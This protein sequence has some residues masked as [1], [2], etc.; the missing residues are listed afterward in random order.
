[1]GVGQANDVLRYLP[2][3]RGVVSRVM[4]VPA[5][6]KVWERG[7]VFQE[8]YLL[9]LSMGGEDLQELPSGHLHRVLHGRIM[10]KL[11]SVT[12]SRTV[13]RNSRRMREYNNEAC[14][15][16]LDGYPP[17]DSLEIEDELDSVL[18]CLDPLE[19]KVVKRGY[20][21]GCDQLTRRSIAAS[22]RCSEG[23]VY[24]TLRSAMAK[25]RSVATSHEER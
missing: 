12:H 10:D 18:S 25:L 14:K 4:K 3:V 21:V 5:T 19:L 11:K 13:K 15:R 24:N 22:L 7:D 1:M 9:L 17:S 6:Y 2:V 20:G 16:A 23:T 8:C